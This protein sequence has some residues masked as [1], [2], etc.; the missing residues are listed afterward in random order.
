MG[1]RVTFLPFSGVLRA[2]VVADGVGGRNNRDRINRSRFGVFFFLPFLIN[3]KGLARR[4]C[5]RSRRSLTNS[6]TRISKKQTTYINRMAESFKIVVEGVP[7][8]QFR[9]GKTVNYPKL[10]RFV[11]LN[12]F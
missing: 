8:F 1:R 4:N 12:Y 9:S 5:H 11:D 2:A 7:P 6:T 10:E 3:S